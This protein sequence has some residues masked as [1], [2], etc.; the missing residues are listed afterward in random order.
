MRPALQSLLKRPS[1]LDLLRILVGTRCGVP[2]ISRSRCSCKDIDRARG[3]ASKV[4]G[5]SCQE[6]ANLNKEFPELRLWTTNTYGQPVRKIP[7]RGRKRPKLARVNYGP[8]EDNYWNTRDI[9]YES[10]LEEKDPSRPKLIDNPIHSKDIRLWACLLD[11]RQRIHGH[12]STRMF[13]RAVQSGSFDLPTTG[14]LSRR[15]WLTFLD[16]G[17]ENDEVLQEILLYTDRLLATTGERWPALYT[18]IIQNMLLSG[19]GEEA[20]QLHHRLIDTHPPI[21]HYFVKMCR[22]VSFK[23]E[24]DA[25]SLIYIFKENDIRGVYSQVVLTLC[26]R[27]EFMLAYKWHFVLVEK[28]DLPNSAT[29]VEPLVRFLAVYYT[30]KAFN[31]TRSLEKAGVSFASSLVSARIENTKIS[32]EMMNLIHGDVLQIPVKEYNDSLGARWF[33]TRWI[34]L[35]IAMNGISAL[36]IQQ[37]G[38]LSLQAIALR[39]PDVE[40]VTRRI[41]QLQD[42]SISIGNSTFSRALEK[43]ARSGN[44]EFLD[45]LIR[46]DQHPNE[47][48]DRELQER[49]LVSY[50]RMQ[51]WSQY[52]RTLAIRLIGAKCPGV[53]TENIILRG[54][55][56]IGDTSAVLAS[57]R[58]MQVS[59]IPVMPTTISRII[60]GFMRHRQLGKRPMTPRVKGEKDDL[61]LIISIL[62]GIIES[63]SFVPA[64]YWRE[65]IKRLGMLD[66]R[67]SELK[68]LCLFL[69]SWYGP[70]NRG[71]HLDPVMRQKLHR[72]QVPKGVPT[73]HPLHPLR[74]VLGPWVQGTIVEWGFIQALKPRRS[75]SSRSGIIHNEDS[76]LPRITAGI[77]LLKRLHE[78]GVHIDMHKVRAAIINRLIVYYG[79]G[80]SNRVYNRV[81]RARNPFTLRQMVNQISD[82]LGQRGFAEVR[83]EEAIYTVGRR[84]LMKRAQR[85][86]RHGKT[87]DRPL[88]YVPP[89]L[90]IVKQVASEATFPPVHDSHG[91]SLAAI[92]EEELPCAA[93][94]SHNS[95]DDTSSVTSNQDTAGKTIY[96]SIHSPHA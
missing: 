51:D 23:Q 41:N 88:F 46:S 72:Y 55:V 66:G 81:D 59:G 60:S 49:L 47:L 86:L 70:T 33:A 94:P 71:E 77:E 3:Y 96:R 25:E 84:R 16:L 87:R 69:A 92:S 50:A 65:I 52:R 48:E 5:G 93:I 73:N 2:N 83:L 44:Q 76:I 67:F 53:E 62:R 31:I 27:E 80:M 78:Y 36:G 91:S 7:P 89:Q 68:D 54:H 22:E 32:R 30:Q 18:T 56:H 35:D 17:F 82:A 28:G 61:S 13:W 15:L 95:Y 6:P 42:L 10:N 19:R 85:Q 34:S 14:P 45:G 4:V 75:L 21:A 63:G 39:E 9:D 38:P 64:S 40:S 11:Y 74:I 20:K 57:L 26:K 90:S 43:F 1:S 79:P 29:D 8:W 58:K 37:I 24:G 12:D